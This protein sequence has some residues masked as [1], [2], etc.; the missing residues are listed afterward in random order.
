MTRRAPTGPGDHYVRSPYL[1]LHP[2]PEHSHA[3][4]RRHL[5]R[6]R[7]FRRRGGGGPGRARRDP[8][9]RAGARGRDGGFLRGSGTPI[10]EPA[11][12]SP[13][14]AAGGSSQARPAHTSVGASAD[15]ERASGGPCGLSSID[16]LSGPSRLNGLSGP[17]GGDQREGSRAGLASR[18]PAGHIGA[19]RR[20]HDRSPV[21]KA[22][23]RVPGG[24]DL[25]TRY[26]GGHDLAK[27]GSAG[28]RPE[29]QEPASTSAP[30][31]H[32]A[33]TFAGTRD[34]VTFACAREA[35]IVAGTA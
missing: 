23:T 1:R 25:A 2:A 34:A 28:P 20:A 16:S 35:I 8:Y 21:T 18:L 32:E 7:S 15:A 19:A 14:G 29:F 5:R 13:A 12:S 6:R 26:P 33:I 30:M 3:A 22:L 24:Q 9:R 31:W 11:C 10:H 4:H 17:S 27:L